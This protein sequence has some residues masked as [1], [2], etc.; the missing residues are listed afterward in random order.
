MGRTPLPGGVIVDGQQ[1]YDE[2]AK[3]LTELRE[4][5]EGTFQAPP[6]FLVG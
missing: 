6:Q 1:I 2:A 5:I 3:E 4:L